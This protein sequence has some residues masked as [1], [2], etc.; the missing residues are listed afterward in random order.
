MLYTLGKLSLGDTR[1]TRLKPL[2]LLSYLSL[3]GRQSRKHLSQLFWSD[4]KDPFGD[5]S[6]ALSRL[7]QA[8]PGSVQSDQYSVESVMSV[9]ALT[10]SQAVGQGNYKAAL[11]LY[12]GPFLSGVIL[13]D[14]SA[15][16]ETWVYTT[17]ETL[18]A[19]AQ[20]CLLKLAER[21][22]DNG[23]TELAAQYAETAYSLSAAPALEAETL[24]LIFRLLEEGGHEAARAVA[25]EAEELGFTLV[26]S[27][28]PRTV[29]EIETT[30]HNLPAPSSSFVGRQDELTTLNLQL[31]D[32]N[33]R[34]LTLMGPGGIGKSRLAL[35]VAYAQLAQTLF[36]DGVYLVALETLQTADLVPTRIAEALELSLKGRESHLSLVTSYIGQEV[37]AAR[38]G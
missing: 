21:Y 22:A 13:P 32:P 33:C 16:L 28:S 7:R 35:S 11:E 23:R 31:S 17:R 12:K 26:K 10:F 3:E 8:R 18:A 19:E 37:H 14:W 30:L 5:L 9:D 38:P 2:V 27:T 15:P 24:A 6:V 34:L 36:D 1:F 25:A 29:K 4:A 20:T